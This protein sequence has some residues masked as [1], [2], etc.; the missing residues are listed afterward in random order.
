[1]S[2]ASPAPARVRLADLDGEARTTTSLVASLATRLSLLHAVSGGTAVGSL[3]AGMAALGREASLTA[4]GARLRAA[5][6]RGRPGVNGQALWAALRI[7]QW[8]ALNP[9]APVLDHVRNDMALLLAADLETTLADVPSP[10]RIAG[11]RAVEPL[12]DVT[13]LDCVIGLWAF[14]N[15]LSRAVEA[16]AAATEVPPGTV[17]VPAH[18][19]AAPRATLLR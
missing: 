18:D 4:D 11:A 15:E 7:P 16:L 2:A 12:D 14:S 3:M 8:L 17:D 10:G 5:I 13:F 6:E 19:D 9:P 1:M